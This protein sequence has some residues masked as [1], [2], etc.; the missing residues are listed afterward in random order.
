MM[1]VGGGVGEA[2]VCLTMLR[3][4]TGTIFNSFDT[5]WYGHGLNLQPGLAKARFKI[6]AFPKLLKRLLVN[7]LLNTY[8]SLYIY[9]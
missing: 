2:K 9:I 5:I 7:K 1:G 8:A 4:D 6:K 3:A